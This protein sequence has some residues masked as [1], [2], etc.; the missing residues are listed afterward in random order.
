MNNRF[1]LILILVLFITDFYYLA[2]YTLLAFM[3]DKVIDYLK[4]DD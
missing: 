4:G 1:I 2:A 3:I